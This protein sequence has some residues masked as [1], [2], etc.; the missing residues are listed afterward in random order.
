MHTA[1]KNTLRVIFII[2]ASISL[3]QSTTY[4]TAEK[5]TNTDTSSPYIPD[6]KGIMM[7]DYGRNI[8]KVYN[9]LIIAQGG[10]KYHQNYLKDNNDNKSKEY[11]INTADWLV[12]HAE[13]KEFNGIHYS[14]W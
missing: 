5:N 6:E 2:A 13:E 8:G 9:P 14:L 11:F 7:Y 3:L 1:T 12:N 10:Q 4:V